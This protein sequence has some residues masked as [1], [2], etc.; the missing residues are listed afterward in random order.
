VGEKAGRIPSPYYKEPAEGE[1]ERDF[2][3]P[4]GPFRMNPFYERG[5]EPRDVCLSMPI[6]FTL[7]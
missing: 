1:I 3:I 4:L 7:L 2:K 6:S 5:R